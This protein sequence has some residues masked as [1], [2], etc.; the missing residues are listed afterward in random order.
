MGS[1]G[2]GA[3][4]RVPPLGAYFADQPVAR[5]VE[6]ARLSAEVTHAHPEG[7]A[8]VIAVAVATALAWRGRG[9]RGPLGSEWI[10]AVLDSVPRGYT[11]DAID[12]ALGVPRD[13]TIIDAAK[14][15]GNGSGVT[16]PVWLP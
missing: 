6:Q 1:F 8:G 13:A 12:R 5:I 7:I 4:M 16:A 3:A 10:R 9:N 14:A 15:L 2:N 11:F